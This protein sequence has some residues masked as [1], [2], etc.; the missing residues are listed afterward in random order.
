ML[1]VLKLLMSKYFY[2]EASPKQGKLIHNKSN[3]DGKIVWS[4]III[5]YKL[6]SVHVC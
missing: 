6:P 5:S 2:A 1:F 3:L 4:E